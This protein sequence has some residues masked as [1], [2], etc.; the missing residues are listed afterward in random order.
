MADL[1]CLTNL[2]HYTLQHDKEACIKC[3]TCQ[4]RCPLF[5]ISMGE[6]GYP[7]VA[8]QCL[9]CGQCAT[10]CPVGARKLVVK[11]DIYELPQTLLDDYNL[12]AEYRL[13]NGMIH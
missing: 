1:N 12:K 6:E 9:R 3:G 8:S 5:A 11:E 7:V 2:S 4:P 10:V 13:S